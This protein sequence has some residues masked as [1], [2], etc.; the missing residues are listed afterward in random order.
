M[1]RIEDATG[2]FITNIKEAKEG[3]PAQINTVVKEQF[4][5]YMMK[6]QTSI[7]LLN[8]ETGET[9][10]IPNNRLSQVHETTGE[11]MLM[12][13]FIES[14]FLKHVSPFFSK[15]NVLNIPEDQMQNLDK[16]EWEVKDL[17]RAYKK[18]YFEYHNIEIRIPGEAPVEM[19]VDEFVENMKKEGQN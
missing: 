11:A 6:H 19:M 13:R 3:T 12:A 17:M 4:L 16:F 5:F 15:D 9:H 18:K 14:E 2:S 10:P 8:H 7:E 1:A